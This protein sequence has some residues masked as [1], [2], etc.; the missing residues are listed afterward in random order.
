MPKRILSVLIALIFLILTVNAVNADEPGYLQIKGPPNVRIFLDGTF[1]GITS[2]D[3]GGIIFS[4]VPIG[5]HKI[6][7]EMEGFN[8]I[9]LSVDIKAGK[10]AVRE[11]G[12]FTP[13]I[14]IEQVGI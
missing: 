1:K 12:T 2:S 4:G 3:I 7:A 8:P 14:K 13:E 10:V 9:N 11:I 6:M 5:A